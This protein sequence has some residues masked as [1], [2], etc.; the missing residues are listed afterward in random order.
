MPLIGRAV[1]LVPLA[2]VLASACATPVKPAE[3]IVFAGSAALVQK[4]AVDALL[5]IGCD[6]ERREPLYVEGHRPW[7]MGWVMSSGGETVGIWLEP[8]AGARTRVRV[9]TATR[10]FGQGGQRDWTGVVVREM[11]RVLGNPE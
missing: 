7:Q 10:L 5:V 4:A 11:T 8:V 1:A 3:S 9:H 6:I 2:L